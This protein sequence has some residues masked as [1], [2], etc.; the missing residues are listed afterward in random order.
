M[1]PLPQLFWACQLPGAAAPEL[2]F[3]GP[4]DATDAQAHW[5]KA[6]PCPKRLNLFLSRTRVVSRVGDAK[7]PPRYRTST[8]R[9]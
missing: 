1:P 5:A 8:L 9:L 4:T 3:R 7:M 6:Q 2:A